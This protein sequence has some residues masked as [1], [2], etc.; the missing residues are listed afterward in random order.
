MS[1]KCDCS[2]PL[3]GVPLV[4][5]KGNLE[6]RGSPALRET[7]APFISFS[8]QIL[9]SF[10]FILFFLA[11]PHGM[12][13]P[14]SPTRDRTPAPGTGSTRVHKSYFLRP[15]YVL[16]SLPETHC[17]VREVSVNQKS[18]RPWGCTSGMPYVHPTPKAA[19][20]AFSGM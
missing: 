2:W 8:P 14:S 6:K 15:Y 9:F 13:D 1:R 12:W 18:M 16:L 11:T 10:Y 5:M 19:G 17:L 7:L 20:E 3:W 4:C